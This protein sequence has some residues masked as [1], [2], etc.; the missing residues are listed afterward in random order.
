MFILGSSDSLEQAIEDRKEFLLQATL[1]KTRA[2]IWKD[3]DI[4]VTDSYI[5]ERR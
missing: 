4:E 1:D 3:F 2:Q 5:W